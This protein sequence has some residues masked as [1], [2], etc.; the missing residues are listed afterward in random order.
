MFVALGDGY[1]DIH[2]KIDIFIALA[3]VVS[4]GETEDTWWQSYTSMR[5][6][7]FDWLESMGIYEMFDD[8]WDSLSDD[9]C[10][11]FQS[12]C[13]ANPVRYISPTPNLDPVTVT[14]VN[15]RPPSPSSIKNIAHYA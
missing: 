2:K 6:T 1:G 4:I 9:F 13:D 11:Y 12:I 15:L 14:V 3:P 10:F 7:A 8:D 5:G